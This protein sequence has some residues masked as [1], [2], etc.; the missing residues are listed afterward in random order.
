MPETG[1]SMM[2]LD[3][4]ETSTLLQD[5]EPAPS[6]GSTLLGSQILLALG[7]QQQTAVDYFKDKIKPEVEWSFTPWKGGRS[8][9]GPMTT[10]PIPFDDDGKVVGSGIV[11]SNDNPNHTH[12]ITAYVVSDQDNLG[13]WWL[14]TA[15]ILY[16]KLSMESAVE[17]TIELPDNT[18]VEVP[19]YDSIPLVLDQDTGQD[20]V[21]AVKNNFDG[22]V[23]EI[24]PMHNNVN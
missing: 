23:H 10:V 8:P 20:L 4:N 17:K 13:K 11:L 6:I 21:N 9:Y 7:T 12:V 3:S 22:V 2:S 5:S 14:S 15:H 19:A 24:V 1:G 18:T 16:I